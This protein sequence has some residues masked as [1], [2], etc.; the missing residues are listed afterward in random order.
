M[1]GFRQALQDCALNDMGY[2]GVKHTWSNNREGSDFT[3]ERL[4]R[5]C[6]NTSCL[7][8]FPSID[9]TTIATSSSDHYPL[10]TV[11][12][13]Q[14]QPARRKERLFRYEYCWGINFDCKDLISTVW[15]DHGRHANSLAD[16][17]IKMNKCK[18]HLLK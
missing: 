16:L 17:K 9:V 10:F 1:Q 3:K 4:D 15:Q 2:N 18:K 5:V 14:I 8:L 11:M 12:N 7:S 13:S 6:A